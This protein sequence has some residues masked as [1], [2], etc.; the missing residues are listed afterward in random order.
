MS[1][2]F[3]RNRD[4][5]RVEW[6]WTA[7]EIRHEVDSLAKS[8]KV[9]PKAARFTHATR[10]CEHGANLVYEVRRAYLHYPNTP[11]GVI[12][13]KKYFQRAIDNCWFIVEDL[14]NIK[15]EGYPVNVNRFDRIADLLDKEIR[16]LTSWKRNTKLTGKATIE[17]RIEQKQLEIAALQ[18]LAAISEPA[19]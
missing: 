11:R 1:G 14:Q 13:R 9:I 2:V 4:M 10:L 18:D 12:D 6:V 5:S 19:N 15:D 3:E 7:R 16:L 17:Q 8:E